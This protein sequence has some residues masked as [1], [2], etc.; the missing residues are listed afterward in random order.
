MLNQ[1]RRGNLVHIWS[2]VVKVFIETFILLK[3]GESHNHVWCRTTNS[4]VLGNG[5]GYSL[6]ARGTELIVGDIEA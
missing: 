5:L 1:R 6:Y 4:R 3:A 2:K